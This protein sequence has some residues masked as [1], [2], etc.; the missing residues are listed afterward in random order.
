[1]KDEEKGGGFARERKKN[2]DKAIYA[3]IGKK[4]EEMMT[5]CAKLKGEDEDEDE[6]DG[7]D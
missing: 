5:L 4:F 7:E 3:E 2:G 1:M 6:D